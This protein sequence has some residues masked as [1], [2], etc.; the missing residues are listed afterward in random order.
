[1]TH[2]TE[3][4]E[5][6]RAPDRQIPVL[7]R[8]LCVA[9]PFTSA[10][11]L[12][13]LFRNVNAVLAPVL[14]A[15]F[16]LASTTMGFMTAAFLGALAGS[17]LFVGQALDRFGPKRVL[18]ATLS[19]AA[20]ASI[21]FALAQNPATLVLGR[22][23]IGLGLCACWTGAYK[24]NALWWPRERLPLVNALTIGVAGLGSLAA[25]VPAEWLL[26]RIDWREMFF[27]LAAAAG[28]IAL[29]IACA[30]PPAPTTTDPGKPAGLPIRLR[31]IVTH[32]A[33]LC[34]MPVS[35]LCQGAWIAYQGLWAGVWLRGA[36][37]LP[38]DAAAGVL[39]ALAIAVIMGQCLFGLLADRLAQSD[40]ALFHLT[41]ALTALFILTQIAICAAPGTR[42]NLLWICYGLFT[43][44]PILAYALLVR[45]LP[46]SVS[47]RA[48]ALLNLGAVLSGFIFQGGIGAAI[49][50]L[51]AF[52]QD[53]ATAQRSVLFGIVLCQAVALANMW[54]RRERAIIPTGQTH[55]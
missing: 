7:T 5:V 40:K 35:A 38:P 44:G 34:I 51:L 41:F 13:E 48:I 20:F 43:A 33:F 26:G 37:D 21:L 25:T 52:G 12:S 3:R 46:Q 55:A 42:Q 28:G 15:E 23:L 53:P 27:G 30:V 14:R 8:L 6:A 32:P 17:Q 18:V 22:F 4:P 50:I 11:L 45:L 29:W 39:M 9:L 19:L 31:A 54:L 16:H 24:A 47:G 49:D 36:I 1:M 2:S 10:Y